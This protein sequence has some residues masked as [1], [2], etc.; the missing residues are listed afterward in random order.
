M[1]FLAALKVA[2]PDDDRDA[3]D[4]TAPTS[5]PRA[6]KAVVDANAL[7]KGLKLERLAEEAITIP[8][9]LSEI[10]D[11]QARR[12]LATLPFDLVVRDPD[13]ES[14][15]V[16]RRF[17]RMTG[18]LG[19]LSEPDVK[20]IALAYALERETHGVAHL[21]AE[22]PP[23]TLSKRTHDSRAKKPGWDF[24]PD[25]DEWAELDALNAEAERAADEVAGRMASATM[26]DDALKRAEAARDVPMSAA[27]RRRAD[28]RAAVAAASEAAKKAAAAA[29]GGGGGEEGEEGD[30]GDDGD[31]WEQNVCRT[32]RIRRMKREARRR[33]AEEEAAREAALDAA[34]GVSTVDGGDGGDG[35]DG[36]S[37][38]DGDDGESADDGDDCE[39]ADA[40][41]DEAAAFFA[42]NPEAVPEGA[43][44]EDDEDEEEDEEDAD[45]A[46]TTIESTVSCVTADYAMQNVILQMNLK[47]LTP[48]G[49]R[50]TSLRRWVLRCHAC[51]EVT[52]QTTRVF[53]PKCGNA[54]LQKVEHTVSSDGVEQFGVRRKHV[55][56]GTR[57]SLP[58]PKGGRTTKQPI[59]RED[60]LIGMRAKRDKAMDDVFACEFN[61]ESFAGKSRGSGNGRDAAHLYR[62]RELLE[63]ASGGNLKKNPNERRFVRTNRRR[64]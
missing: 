10:K 4:A 58:A 38:D 13:E 50:I 9:V 56:K 37:A 43:E 34:A 18:D 21:R 59:L 11:A 12:A 31:G 36:E 17:A 2:A 47:L 20:V 48:D 33:E 25:E 41:A 39:S 54:S 49:M 42:S 60:Q 14:I 61:E 45:G 40:R 57:Y 29:D 64:K 3:S 28:E 8:E 44:D 22:P 46:S 15:K 26:D 19:A 30:D 51:G 24:V 53:C 23:V 1:S 32:T 63:V 55:L 27:E 5:R 62:Q 35:G 52:R 7:I 6:T 16:V